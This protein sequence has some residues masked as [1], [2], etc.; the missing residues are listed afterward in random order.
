ML[1]TALSRTQPILRRVGRG[2]TCIQIHNNGPRY[3]ALPVNS[4]QV[5]SS[6]F[7]S[8]SHSD[9]APKRKSIDDVDEAMKIIKS[10]VESNRIMLYMKGNPSQPMCGFS[11]RVVNIL[12]KEGADFSSV[13]VLDYPSIREGVKKFSYVIDRSTAVYCHVPFEI[14]PDIFLFLLIS[15][16]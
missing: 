13:N 3:S 2:A 8:D 7:S 10:H 15:M 6:L 5:P 14:K 12:K 9:F 16:Q 4:V 11:A 1:R